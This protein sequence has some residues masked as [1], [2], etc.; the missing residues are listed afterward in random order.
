VELFLKFSGD[1]PLELTRS[2]ERQ[3]EV[4][5]ELVHHLY[6]RLY[7]ILTGSAHRL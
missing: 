1:L 6:P 4:G 2:R 7:E 5:P 3:F